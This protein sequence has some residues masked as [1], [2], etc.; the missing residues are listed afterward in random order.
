M[1]TSISKLIKQT[2]TLLGLVAVIT[3]ATGALKLESVKAAADPQISL[4]LSTTN[5]S[6]KPIKLSA[7]VTSSSDLKEVKYATGSHK[8][9]YFTNEKYASKV[10]TIALSAS[11]ESTRTFKIKKNATYTFYAIDVNGNISTQKI[12]ITNMEKEDKAVWVSFLEFSSN[13]YDEVSFTEHIN[14]MFDNIQADNFTTVYAVVRPFSDA[15][16]PSKYFP[17]SKYCS[18]EQGKNPG[19]DPLQIMVDAAKARDLKIFAY[20]NPY[21]VCSKADFKKI[22][23]GSDDHEEG[24]VNPASP[25]YTW[26]N[27]GDSSTDRNV[28]YF[29]NYYYY[30]PA[31]PEVR[32]LII[33]GVQ[34]IVENYD[35]DGIIFDD[36]FYPTLG[37]KYKKNFDYKEYNAYVKE[38]KDAEEIPEFTNIADWRRNN[39]NLLVKGVYDTVKACDDKLEF[40]I[41]PAGNIENLKSD[42]KY[43]VDIDAWCNEDGYIDFIAPQQYWG[44]DHS[45][46]PFEKNVKKWIDEVGNDNVKLYITLPMHDAEAKPTDEWRQNDDILARMIKSIRNKEDKIEGFSIFRYNFLTDPYLKSS[47]AKTERDKVLKEMK[48]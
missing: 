33:N 13:G 16:Y 45:I 43:Y 32:E 40:G 38:C 1:Y 14:D 37:A 19:Y 30:N 18:G 31:V 6:V 39:I 46:C 12:T 29:S 47:G 2:L 15:M 34:E 23:K 11:N 25:A 36:Y 4:T 9:G 17:F 35:V 20:I 22:Y 3:A 48:K 27:D 21:R 24:T 5:K 44:F 10:K 8:A 7:K 41:S 42:Q 26:L 28:L